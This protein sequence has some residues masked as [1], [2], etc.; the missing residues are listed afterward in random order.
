MLRKQAGT[1]VELPPAVNGKY[2]E[3]QQHEIVREMCLS[4]HRSSLNRFTY[5]FVD[6]Q[7]SDLNAVVYELDGLPEALFKELIEVIVGLGDARN[8]LRLTRFL[9]DVEEINPVYRLLL[10]N[11]ALL[12]SKRILDKVLGAWPLYNSSHD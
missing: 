12:R 9:F 11:R 5:S 4:L 10:R 7:C 6:A 8:E 2:L 1:S 3:P